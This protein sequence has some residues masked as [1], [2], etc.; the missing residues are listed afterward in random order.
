MDSKGDHGESLPSLKSLMRL[1][2]KYDAPEVNSLPDGYKTNTDKEKLYLWS[3][4]NFIR[5]IRHKY[6]TLKPL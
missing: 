6:P 5:Q 1:K 3:A 4:N 2:K